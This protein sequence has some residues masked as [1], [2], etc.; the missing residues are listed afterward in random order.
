[1]T[2][3]NLTREEKE[4]LLELALSI[5]EWELKPNEVKYVNVVNR[6]LASIE[7]LSFMFE[8]KEVQKEDGV[9][10]PPFRHQGAPMGRGY[11]EVLRSYIKRYYHLEISNKDISLIILNPEDFQNTPY[12]F[13]FELI[14]RKASSSEC[15][16]NKRER[17]EKKKTGFEKLKDLFKFKRDIKE[18]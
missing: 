18:K 17:E 4:N 14:S 1:M 6:Y 7:D 3:S 12:E 8:E 9:Y 11:Y 2:E 15:K 16:K 13:Y 10:H 5:E